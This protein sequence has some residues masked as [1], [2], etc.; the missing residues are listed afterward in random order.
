MY[1][2]DPVGKSV[3]VTYLSHSFI[4]ACWDTIKGFQSRH[5]TVGCVKG[6]G[7]EEHVQRYRG[8]Y[9][10]DDVDTMV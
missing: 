2:Q 3:F 5:W 1:D 8:M 7:Y 9:D 6:F 4:C 10:Q